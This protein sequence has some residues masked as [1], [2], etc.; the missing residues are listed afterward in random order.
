M[1][2]PM[3]EKKD[4]P[5]RRTLPEN[6]WLKRLDLLYWK[7]LLKYFYIRFLRMQGSPGAIARGVAAGMFAGSF[8][9]LGFQTLI[10]IAIAAMVRGNKVMAAVGTW[11][12][13]PLTYVPIF[14]LNFHIG[15]MLLRFPKETVLPDASAGMEE[16]MSLGMTTTAALMVGSLVTG[17][18]A[19]VIGYYLAFAVAHRVRSARRR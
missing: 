1:E 8:P 6:F 11:I 19:G 18:I 3:A 12:S 5:K 7:R 15:R 17:V 16:W 13:N 4:K 10:G 2:R 14:A 9:F